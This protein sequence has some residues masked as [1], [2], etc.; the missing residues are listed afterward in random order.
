MPNMQERLE[1]A[2]ERT[3]TDSSLFHDMVH[4]PDSATVITENGNVPTV[5]KALKD[6]RNE[7]Y[8]QASSLVNMAQAAANEAANSLTQAQAEVQNTKDEVQN[9]KAEV[10][11]A[12]TE[13]QNAK[14]EVSK[15]KAEVT[16]AQTEVENAKQAAQNAHAE[17][18]HA[19][20]EVQNAKAE[21]NKAKIW[22]EGSDAEVQTQGGIHSCQTWVEM[23]QQATIGSFPITVTGIA[24]AN[25][26]VLPLN[27]AEAITNTDQILTVIIENTALLPETY[28]ISSN[29]QSVVLA[30]PLAS[31]ERWSVKCLFALQSMAGMIDC[32]VYEEM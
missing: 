10:Q 22:A 20:A 15:A 28:G 29:G 12:K 2:I 24:T 23:A 8:G 25:Q 11:N 21:V 31:G 32:V 4:G 14:N 16:K 18:V 27:L 17:V 7:L 30:N 13:V 9:A 6:I 3:E 26:T 19:Q 5:A 1:T